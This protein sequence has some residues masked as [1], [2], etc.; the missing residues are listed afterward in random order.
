MNKLK[1]AFLLVLFLN[2][3]NSHAGIVLSSTRVIYSESSKEV[4]LKVTNEETRPSLTQIWL[5]KGD[6][7]SKPQQIK[8][9]FFITPVFSR[10]DGKK[11][12]TYRIFKTEDVSSLP[13]DRE[14][15]F[16]LNVLDIPPKP[17]SID[18]KKSGGG[19]QFS[20]RTRIKFFYRPVNLKGVANQAPGEATFTSS[21]NNI[22]IRND[23]PY[24]LNLQSF[25]L[26]QF[27]GTKPSQENALVPPFS[28][29]I[30]SFNKKPPKGT[31]LSYESINDLGGI[32]N[33]EKVI[34]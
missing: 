33:Y 5:D 6:K 9:P 8:V 15:I 17:S 25:K 10:I 30:I 13:S 12:Q 7:D 4:T 22:I 27:P 20:V 34:L 24:H 16:Y 3:N 1:I 18:D 28:E 31:A 32:F 14:S 26:K 19:I 11:T 23:T 2:V 21:G 29:K